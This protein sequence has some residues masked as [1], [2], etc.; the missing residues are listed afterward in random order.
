ML[1]R[2]LREQLDTPSPAERLAESC[3]RLAAD[4]ALVGLPLRLSVFGLTRLPH[5]RWRCCRHWRRAVRCTC[6]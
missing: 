5:P 3:E 1:W 2:R 6:G 4:P